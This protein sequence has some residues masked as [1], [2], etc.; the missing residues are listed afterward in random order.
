MSQRGRQIITIRRKGLALMIAIAGSLSSCAPEYDPDRCSAFEGPEAP[1]L[2]EDGKACILKWGQALST[3][4]DQARDVAVAVL[5]ACA[6]AIPNDQVETD[7]EGNVTEAAK[8]A[9][10]AE[11]RSLATFR[12][13]EERAGHCSKK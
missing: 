4:H 5:A 3:S 8:A 12:V 7:E 6:D 9:T 1:H 10:W 13:V 11:A 2:T